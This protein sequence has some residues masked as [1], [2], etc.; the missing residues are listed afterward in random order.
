MIGDLFEDLVQ[1]SVSSVGGFSRP[2]GGSSCKSAGEGSFVFIGPH[3]RLSN[4]EATG[5]V[6]RPAQ[7]IQNFRFTVP[8]SARVR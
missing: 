7:L 5:S 3:P 8:E 4:M 2:A 1:I 6:G